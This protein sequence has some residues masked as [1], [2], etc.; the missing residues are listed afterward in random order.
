MKANRKINRLRS[1]ETNGFTLIELLVVIAIIAV[2][3][4]ML[5]PALSN[6][7]GKATRTS[8][9]SNLKQ[10]GAAL[11]MYAG[12]YSDNLPPARFADDPA[13]QPWKAYELFGNV[14]GA[15]GTPVDLAVSNP[16][17]HGYFYTTK[18]IS[19]GQTFY[20]PSVRSLGPPGSKSYDYTYDNYSG[21]QGWPSLGGGSVRSSYQ[22]YPQSDER[23]NLLNKYWYKVATKSTQLRA[24]RSVMTDLVYRWSMIPH[25]S[26]SNPNALNTLWGDGH[27]TVCT[28]RTAF[29]PALW[30]PSGSDNPGPGDVAPADDFRKIL[31]LLQP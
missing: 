27:A 10:M 6:A 2:L 20:C 26:G 30:M 13:T 16:L 8:C 29:D 4:A 5:L 15:D 31:A 18:L 11:I 28:T 1:R 24:Y 3:A 22:Y 12:D 7:K 17:S 21:P 14:T 19:Q 23:V 9:L 25:R